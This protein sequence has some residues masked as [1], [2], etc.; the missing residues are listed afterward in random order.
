MMRLL[1][2]IMLFCGPAYAALTQAE[3]DSVGVNLPEGAALPLDP[4]VPAVLI[5]ADFD[6]PH[7][8]DAALAQTADQLAETGLV[9]GQDY[10]L[11]VVGMD[12]RDS[13]ATAEE[14]ISRQT[15]AHL[16]AAIT[17]LQPGDEE[18]A[19]MTRALGYGYVFDPEL[20][21]FAHP[22]ARYVLAADGAV[23][24]V[25]P[26]FDASPDALRTA[27]LGARFGTGAAATSL[28]LL[29]YGFDPVTGR[30]SLAIW[31]VLTA[32]CLVTVLMLGGALAVAFRRE[33]KLP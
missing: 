24:A 27:L 29:C 22:A 11:A 4:G 26:A 19:E 32:A 2:I 18:L 28:I 1:A 7:I 5:F 31:R 10:R 14:F 6:C 23:S 25:I 3:L 17:L 15:P 12:P 30:Y 21:R 20:G 9:A 13:A 16:R 33:R 8:C